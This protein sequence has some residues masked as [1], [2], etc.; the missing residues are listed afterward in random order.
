MITATL[1]DGR[2]LKVFF[3]HEQYFE[4]DWITDED[5]DGAAVREEVFIV[6]RH[7]PDTDNAY[8]RAETRC[9]IVEGP[10]DAEIVLATATA[11]CSEDDNFSKEAGRQVALTRALSTNRFSR[12]EVGAIKSAYF[13]RK[14]VVAKDGNTLAGLPDATGDTTPLTA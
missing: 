2:T 13:N 7:I 1:N 9:I 4:T 8:A 3:Q 5:N 10:K 14:R 11:Y 12:E 6:P